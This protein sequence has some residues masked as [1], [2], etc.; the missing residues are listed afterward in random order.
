M[1]DRVVKLIGENEFNKINSKTVAV[2]G[3]GGV[4]GYAVEGLV[5]SGI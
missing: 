3:I 1:F 4:G 5:R 2:I